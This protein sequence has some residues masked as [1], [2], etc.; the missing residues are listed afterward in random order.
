MRLNSR[1]RSG[2]KYVPPQDLEEKHL[3]GYNFCGPGTNVNRRLKNGVKPMNELDE[4]CLRHDLDTERRGPQ[5]AKSAKALKD[6]DKR[7]S[8]AAKSIALRTKDM[9]LRATAWVVHRAMEY[10]TWRKS[11]GGPGPA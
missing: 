8:K 10:S 5:K 4:A 2:P 1:R 11:R 9:K 6:S 7:L 3:P